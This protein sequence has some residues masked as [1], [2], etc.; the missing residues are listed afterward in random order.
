MRKVT[1]DSA[2]VKLT[3]TILVPLLVTISVLLLSQMVVLLTGKLEVAMML[4]KCLLADLSFV[5]ASSLSFGK[6][7]ASS[8]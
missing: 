8:D 1:V 3:V 4:G 7:L 2:A 5:H 6:G